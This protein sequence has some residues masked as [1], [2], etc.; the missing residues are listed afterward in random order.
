MAQRSTSTDAALDNLR[1]IS[2]RSNPLCPYIKDSECFQRLP[3]PQTSE[4]DWVKKAAEEKDRKFLDEDEEIACS[5]MH[6]RPKVEYSLKHKLRDHVH[7]LFSSLAKLDET[8]PKESMTKATYKFS[9]RMKHELA[10]IET[11]NRKYS[12]PDT[13]WAEQRAR[14]KQLGMSK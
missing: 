13:K 9:D 2:N 11:G 14:A 3:G 7:D 1:L 4:N 12:N 6:P 5:L 10:T 8:Q